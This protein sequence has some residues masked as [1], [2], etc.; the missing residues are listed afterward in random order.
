MIAKV[1]SVVAVLGL[2]VCCGAAAA[3]NG[4]STYCSSAVPSQD[5]SSANSGQDYDRPVSWKRLVP[6]ILCDQKQI[7]LFPIKAAEGHD[8]LPVVSVVGATAGLATLDPAEGR[9]FHQSSGFQGFNNIFTSNGTALATLIAPT[10][11][12]FAGLIRKDTKMQHTALLAGEAVADSEIVETVLKDISNRARPSTFANHSNYWDSWFEGK[13][14]KVSGGGSF[15]SGHTIVAF[16]IA[17]VVAHRYR[18]HRWVPYVAYGGAAVI[19]FSRL[20]LSAHFA[21]DVF[22]GAAL[23]YSISRFAV[24][25]Y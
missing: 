21:S 8:W 15:P 6:N 12:Y 10:S 13:G 4:T 9:Y 25:Q 22:V 24:L 7:W 20:S 19:A 2:T 5:L 16:S 23:G 1:S 14:S 17:T 18:T 3:Q 11:I